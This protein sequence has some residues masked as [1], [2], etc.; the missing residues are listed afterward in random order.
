M[1]EGPGHH[2]PALFLNGCVDGGFPL[3]KAHPLLRI[4]PR[5]LMG[6]CL[7]GIF[8]PAA[9]MARWMITGRA[10]QQGTSMTRAVMLLISAILNIS[11]AHLKK[12]GEKDGF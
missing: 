3:K 4:S 9:S 2:D 7:T 1:E 12:V 10:E 8:L 5:V 6:T 11:G